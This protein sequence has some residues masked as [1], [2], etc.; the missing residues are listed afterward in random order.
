MENNENKYSI[1]DYIIVTIGF[2]IFCI[3]QV[4]AAKYY[5]KLDWNRLEPIWTIYT[6]IIAGFIIVAVFSAAY[7]II[8]GNSNTPKVVKNKKRSK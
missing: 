5:F 1:S 4:I 3:L 7:D 2:V 6:P 8:S